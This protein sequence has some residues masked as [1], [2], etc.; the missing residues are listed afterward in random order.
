MHASWL[1]F[2]QKLHYSFHHKVG[3]SNKVADAL[4]RKHTLLSTFQLDLKAFSHLKD[5]Y[6]TDEDF[7][8]IWNHC[9]LNNKMDGYHI[10]DGY[11]F[12]GNQLCIPRTSLREYIIQD[13]HSGGLAT[14]IGRDKTIANVSTRFYWPKMKY[15]IMDFI[16]KCGV[17]QRAKGHVQNIGLY[18]P[19]PVPNTIWEDFSMDFIIGL[20]MTQR[21]IDSVY[22]VVD[23]FSKMAHFLP[24]KK[25]S[26]ASYVAHIF[27]REVVRL[28]CIPKSITSDQDVRFI[29]HFWKTLWKRFDTKLQFSSAYHPQTDSQTEVVNYTLGTMLRSLADDKPKQWDAVV[30]EAEFA[31]NSMVNRSTRLAH[32]SIVYTPYS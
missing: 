22:V 24:C 9:I 32:F 3:L 23:R 11:L 10:V 26:D 19:L 7:S 31:Y 25:A 6:D 15:D 13:L 5:L 16:A 29:N 18:T 27:F 1:E 17:C 4:S 20:P 8:T 30:S 14:H 28:H 2:L 21:I 12:K